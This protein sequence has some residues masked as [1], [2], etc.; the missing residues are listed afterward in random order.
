MDCGSGRRLT[1]KRCEPGSRPRPARTSP[2]AG[3]VAPSANGLRSRELAHQERL[4]LGL[5]LATRITLALG[6]HAAAQAIPCWRR[7]GRR[8]SWAG[9]HRRFRLGRDACWQWLWRNERTPIRWEPA[10]LDLATWSAE[11]RARY[12]PAGTTLR[13]RN[14]AGMPHPAA[15]KT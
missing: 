2:V 15:T 10:G 7:G 14:A 8:R 3:R 11:A 1:G 12:A 9:V 5:A 4:V 6:T 13:R